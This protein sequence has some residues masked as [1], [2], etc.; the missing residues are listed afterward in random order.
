MF[1]IFGVINIK[2]IRLLKDFGVTNMLIFTVNLQETNRVCNAFQTFLTGTFP[3]PSAN[4]LKL[5]SMYR[6]EEYK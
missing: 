1:V 5:I 4:F 2:Q 6:P 3:A